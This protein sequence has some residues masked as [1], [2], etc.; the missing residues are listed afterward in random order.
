MTITI[1]G[2]PITTA[3]PA[4]P[5]TRLGK[6]RQL[7][8]QQIAQRHPADPF[9]SLD[10]FRSETVEHRIAVA[11]DLRLWVEQRLDE[12]V[13][14]AQDE[15]WL[16]LQLRDPALEGHRMRQDA[17]ERLQGMQDTIADLACDV[18]RL[19]A[20]SDRIWRSLEISER[21]DMAARWVCEPAEDRLIM[22]AWTRVAQVGFAWPENYRVNRRWFHGLPEPLLFDMEVAG[23]VDGVTLGE[24]VDPF[25]VEEEV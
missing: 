13:P 21:G 19:E 10:S 24:T 12:M 8:V 11:A 4:T 15:A 7:T 17:L 23:L 1:G 6:H 2:K 18:A 9:P 20:H 14:I 5:P 25:E 22:F 3:T 16:R